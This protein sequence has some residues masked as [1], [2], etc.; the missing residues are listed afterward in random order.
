[1]GLLC[2]KRFQFSTFQIIIFGFAAVILTGT[3]LLMLPLSSANGRPA[4]I[5]EALF[6]AT[7][8]VCVTGLV[9][10]DT[11]AGWSPF[12]QAV[13][14][15]LIQI[16]GL[17]V[18]TVASAILFISGKNIS[19]RQRNTLKEALSA[20]NIG[21]IVKLMRFI[22]IGVAAV[23]LAGALLMMP[24]FCSDHGIKGVWMALFH[25]VSAFCNAG[26]DILGSSGA[27]YVSLTGYA[28]N[29]L[30]NVVIMA[31]I[32]IGGIGFLTWN[33][34]V[35]H[36]YHFSR[37]SMQSKVILTVTAVLIVIP[38]FFFY[39]Y[40]FRDL[41]GGER[42]FSSL[43]QVVTPRTAGFNTQDTGSLSGAG[44]SLTILLMLIGGAP[45]SAAGGMKVTTAA[46]MIA[47]AI[48]VFRQKDYAGLFGRR[49]EP[50][51]VR[52]ASALFLMYIL[53]FMGGAFL[54]SMAEGLSMEA[55]LFEAASAVGTVGL[56]TGITPGLGTFSRMVLIG[57][58]FLGRV[59]GLTF[60]YAAFPAR[61]KD[62]AM[63]PL[64]KIMVG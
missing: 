38:A 6:T 58:M 57:L 16:G 32:V 45:G 20:P 55:C 29:A 21:G 4:S 2:R 27:E 14:L 59:G 39:F 63:L 49:I 54:I 17:G 26:F 53:L 34:L 35:I 7:S 64:E 62:G 9:V 37:Y 31:L 41:A 48:A 5:D 56:T 43:F 33:D 15:I 36:R 52:N 61:V 8:A 22:L 24:V 10:R 19:L 42:L 28:G 47:S 3:V 11:A 18:I 12:G 51:A 1:M 40:E 44:R 30:I 25:S 23:E 50:D 46:V 60:I 13:I